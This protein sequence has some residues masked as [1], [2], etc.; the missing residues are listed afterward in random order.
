ML[1]YVTVIRY[2]LQNYISDLTQ[3]QWTLETELEPELRCNSSSVIDFN[4]HYSK[5]GDHNCL[6]A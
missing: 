5:K 2:L 4:P 6:I 3:G 1:N